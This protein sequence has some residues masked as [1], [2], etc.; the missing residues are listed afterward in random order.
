MISLTVSV[1]K[2]KLSVARLI[3]LAELDDIVS[4]VA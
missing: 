1:G 3:A 4:I 2:G